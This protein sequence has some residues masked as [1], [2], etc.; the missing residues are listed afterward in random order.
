MRRAKELFNGRQVEAFVTQECKQTHIAKWC[1]LFSAI[2]SQGLYS[3]SGNAYINA[4]F[5]NSSLYVF[6][7]LPLLFYFATKGYLHG[8]RNILRVSISIFLSSYVSIFLLKLRLFG[9]PTWIVSEKEHSSNCPTKN[10][11]AQL[12]QGDLQ[13]RSW[14]FG[15][16]SINP[17]TCL[18][19]PACIWSLRVQGT[20]EIQGNL[21]N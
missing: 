1:S 18:A 20:L 13:R 10:R 14:M 7:I 12:W 6:S 4:F 17:P 3:V 15:N 11:R 16:S 19:F 2:C 9:Y 8:N 21:S 5:C